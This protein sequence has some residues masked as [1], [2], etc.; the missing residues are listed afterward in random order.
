MCACVSVCVCVRG[1]LDSTANGPTTHTHSDTDAQT[2][3]HT[4]TQTQTQTHTHTHTH[5]QAQTHRN[6]KTINSSTGGG[7]RPRNIIIWPGTG[8]GLPWGS[9]GWPGRRKN[10]QNSKNSH[11]AKL[12]AKKTV[13][14]WFG[15]IG[16]KEK[17]SL[18]LAWG[19]PGAGRE[20]KQPKQ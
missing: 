8:C 3:R 11:F 4:Q 6:T 18:R 1:K 19:S 17:Q 9:W 7:H 15:A 2:R 5:T 13:I 16:E 10:S 20:G 12:F 14:F